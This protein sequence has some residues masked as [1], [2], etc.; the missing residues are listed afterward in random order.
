ML[1]MYE[2]IL[3]KMYKPVYNCPEQRGSRTYNCT[4]TGFRGKSVRK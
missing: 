4:Y 2:P 1:K 3:E